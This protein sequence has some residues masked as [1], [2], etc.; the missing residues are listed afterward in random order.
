MEGAGAGR[1]F[2]YTKC[3]LDVKSDD[4]ATH[5]Q[6]GLKMFIT[7]IMRLSGKSRMGSQADV[8]TA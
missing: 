6:K 3:D 2:P 1:V 7:H 4:S 8:K 5:A